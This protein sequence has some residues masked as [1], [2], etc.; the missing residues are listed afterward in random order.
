MG[1]LWDGDVIEHAGFRFKVDMPNDHDAEHPWQFDGHGPVSDWTRRAKRPGEMVLCEDRGQRRFYDFQK[2]VK[3][4]RADG[5]GS[6]GD[7][8]LTGGAKAAKAALADFDRLRRYCAD[9]WGY[10]AVI[11]SLV[12]DEGE[13]MSLPKQALFGV[14]SDSGDYLLDVATELADEVIAQ[15]KAMGGV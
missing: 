9:Q 7:E 1:R 8:G 15:L 6:Q 11:V 13:D 14:E 12:D 4:A 3:A 2:A 5:W 10:V